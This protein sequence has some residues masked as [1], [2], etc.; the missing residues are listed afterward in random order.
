M[1][2]EHF[3]YLVFDVDV[4]FR[5]FDDFDI[6]GVNAALDAVDTGAPA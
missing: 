2:I 1:L 6:G 5:F 4:M 3:Y